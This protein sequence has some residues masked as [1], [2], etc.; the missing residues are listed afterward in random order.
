[1]AAT[2]VEKFPVPAFFFEVDI[3]GAEVSFQEVSG[4]EENAEVLEYRHGNS[5]SLITQK[6]A[7]L[8]KSSTITLKRGIFHD[9]KD[10]MEMLKKLQ[11]KKYQSGEA[12][13][14]T[15]EIKLLDENKAAIVQWS[16]LKPVPIKWSGPGLKSDSN[17]VAIESMEF[18]HQGIVIM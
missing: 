7:G 2:S 13:L 11:D 5:Q 16:I 3:D 6:R 10:L 18:A 14:P 9:E 15:L 17:E 8:I 1:M 4:L 12:E